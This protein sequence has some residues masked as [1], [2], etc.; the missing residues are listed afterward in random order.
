MDSSSCSP[1]FS[2]IYLYIYYYLFFDKLPEVTEYAEMQFHM[3]TLLDVL[4][5]AQ[6]THPRTGRRISLRY[7]PA[8]FVAIRIGL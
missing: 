6:V 8:S 5:N 1:L 3:M 2:F 7:N 4:V